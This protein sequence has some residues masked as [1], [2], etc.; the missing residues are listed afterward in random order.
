MPVRTSITFP[1]SCSLN[2]YISLRYSRRTCISTGKIK[3]VQLAT[4]VFTEL[5]ERKCV[6]TTFRKGGLT[7]H[8]PEQIARREI[9]IL[10]KLHH[11]HVVELYDAFQ[12]DNSVSFVTPYAQDGNLYQYVESRQRLD[13]NHALRIFA[14][15]LKALDYLHNKGISHRDIKLE[16]VVLDGDVAKLINFNLS[17][18]RRPREEPKL[19]IFSGTAEYMA[20]EMVQLQPHVPERAD[21]WACGLLLYALLARAR[22]LPV[23]PPAQLKPFILNLDPFLMIRSSFLKHVSHPTKLLLRRLLHHNPA[24]RPTAAEALAHLSSLGVVKT[25]SPASLPEG[26]KP[27]QNSSKNTHSNSAVKPSWYEEIYATV[28]GYIRVKRSLKTFVMVSASVIGLSQRPVKDF[29]GKLTG[30]A[31]RQWQRRRRAVVNRTATKRGRSYPQ[32]KPAQ[33]QRADK[34]PEMLP[35]IPRLHQ[36]RSQGTEVIGARK[37]PHFHR[38]DEATVTARKVR[39][40]IDIDHRFGRRA[41]ETVGEQGKTN[42]AAKVCQGIASIFES[43]VDCFREHCLAGQAH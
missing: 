1:R 16:H 28:R 32:I 25:Q 26:D 15:V 31:K 43:T 21:M 22:A 8:A 37:R 14:Q 7:A 5:P 42:W 27:R 35:P 33:S 6:V 18:W 10:S 29:L 3:S 17:H 13:E 36:T 24:M 34:G 19:R 23:L 39:R 40:K 4:D 12:D 2:P 38:E 11:P 9:C 41:D 20:P 30:I